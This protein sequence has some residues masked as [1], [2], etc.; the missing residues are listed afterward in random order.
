MYINLIRIIII[1]LF[2]LHIHIYLFIFICIFL[3]IYSFIPVFYIVHVCITHTALD[4]AGQSRAGEA[5][6]HERIRPL[7]TG[8]TRGRRAKVL[9]LHLGFRL[10]G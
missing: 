3:F 6:G 4:S 5:P 2:C 7:A 9:R 8:Q 10:L 1:I